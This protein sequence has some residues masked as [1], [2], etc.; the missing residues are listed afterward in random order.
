MKNAEKQGYIQRLESEGKRPHINH[1][2]STEKRIIDIRRRFEQD[3]QK[4]AL[5]KT[6][7]TSFQQWRDHASKQKGTLIDIKIP[8]E[9]SVFHLINEEEHV[10]SEH[11]PEK[12]F[13][14]GFIHFE[15]TGLGWKGITNKEKPFTK[16]T[17]FPDQKIPISKAFDPNEA[18]PFRPSLDSQGQRHLRY[19][20]LPANHM[21]WVEVSL[22][23]A[24]S[25]VPGHMCNR[26]YQ[27][28][29]SQKAMARYYEEDG[30]TH[31][32]RTRTNQT[33]SPEL[34]RGQL[35]GSS[36]ENCPIHARHMRSRCSSIPLQSAFMKKRSPEE[37]P[38]Q[39]TDDKDSNSQE[40][41]FAIFVSQMGDIGIF[42]LCLSTHQYM[43]N[44]NNRPQN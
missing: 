23:D 33:L 31:E 15:Q 26:T 16:P 32:Q 8:R 10:P 43:P 38:P 3:E 29:S 28:H 27:E 9:Q 2:E 41:Q 44:A 12:E 39:S 17:E 42:S 36:L 25:Q 30:T 7:R 37:E 35:Y 22:G 6:L 11:V 19:I 5:M 34:W 21:E 20:H 14:I 4:S 24:P 1:L 40:S 13:K 18:N